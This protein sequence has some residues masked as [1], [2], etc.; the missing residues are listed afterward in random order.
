MERSL[1]VE[2]LYS[3]GD[4]KNIKF[5]NTITGIPEELVNNDKVTGLLFLQQV[6]SCEIAYRQYVELI[7]RINKE[8]TVEIGGK[9][10]VNAEEVMQFLQ[11]QRSSTLNELYEEIKQTKENI[12]QQETK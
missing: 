8:F 7:E 1:N 9:K 3:L 6:L 10:I 12:T 4:Y 5:G 11:D 2:R